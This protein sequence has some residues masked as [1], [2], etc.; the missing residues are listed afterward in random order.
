MHHWHDFE[1]KNQRNL[2]AHLKFQIME[3]ITPKRFDKWFGKVATKVTK[4]SGSPIVVVL[5]FL[6]VI[7]WGATGPVFHYSEDWQLIINTSTTIITFLMVFIIQHSQNK[8]TTAMQ[9]KLNE[10]L[11]ANK[12]ASNRVVNIEDL[13][14]PELMLLKGFY[15]KLSDLAEEEKELFTTRSVDEAKQNQE[16]KSS[17]E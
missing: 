1:I 13:S 16:E 14:E 10:L 4:A 8:D 5:A 3:K 15:K 6:S 9:I 17:V 2:H 11:A 12:N 7:I